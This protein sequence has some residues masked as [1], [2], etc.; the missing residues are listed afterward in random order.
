MAKSVTLAVTGSRPNKLK[1]GYD[2]MSSDNQRMIDF[3]TK[4]I[5]DTLA[6]NDKVHCIS[7]GA[8]GA[9]TLWAIAVINCRFMYPGR[10]SLEMAIP[11]TN[12]D[13]NWPDKSKNIYRDL[14]AQADKITNVSGQDLYEPTYMQARNEYMVDNCHGLIA[15]YNGTTGGTHNCVQYAKKQN[16]RILVN[17]SFHK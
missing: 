11:F 6:L 17:S 1:G 9:D 13:G 4:T 12:Q 16:K 2:N 15:I 3:F 5:E 8:L 7:G 14:L 10:V